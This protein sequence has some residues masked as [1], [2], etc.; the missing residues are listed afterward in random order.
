MRASRERVLMALENAESLIS[1]LNYLD[2]VRERLQQIEAAQAESRVRRLAI[3][4]KFNSD[5]GDRPR[6]PTLTTT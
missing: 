1:E 3:S 6:P 5:H 4:N 2:T